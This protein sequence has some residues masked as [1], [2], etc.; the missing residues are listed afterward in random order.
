MD[1]SAGTIVDLGE[2]TAL[3]TLGDG[4]WYS[5]AMS[6]FGGGQGASFANGESKPESDDGSGA[7][8]FC[9]VVTNEGTYNVSAV[10]QSSQR[11]IKVIQT[12][13]FHNLHSIQ[14]PL[15]LGFCWN[16]YV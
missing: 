6:I 9:E 16:P 7:T 12:T 14:P 5:L 8:I 1:S 13:H 10:D 3:P 2:R 11:Y 4:S 15:L